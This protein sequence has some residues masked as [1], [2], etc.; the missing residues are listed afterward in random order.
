[1][2]F[3]PHHSHIT[4][5]ITSQEPRQLPTN[6]DALIVQSEP[7]SLRNNTEVKVRRVISLDKPNIIPLVSSSR[8]ASPVLGDRVR[9]LVLVL[10]RQAR[11]LAAR[12]GNLEP[13]A[14]VAL[15]QAALRV[16]AAGSQSTHV[17]GVVHVYVAVVEVV[18]CYVGRGSVFA[19]EVT[20]DGAMGENRVGVTLGGFESSEVDVFDGIET[21]AAFF[22]ARAEVGERPLHRPAFLGSLLSRTAFA[23]STVGVG[24]VDEDEVQTVLDVADVT[25]TS[26]CAFVFAD[27]AGKAGCTV[28]ECH[29]MDNCK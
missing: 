6:I 20:E 1:M 4:R 26:W 29:S 2:P 11:I 22:E 16:L 28:D 12:P 13:T 24:L 10:P 17:A 14:V 8:S 7:V 23:N 5:P 25:S 15:L 18:E 3:K 27:A 21:V 19:G 9:H